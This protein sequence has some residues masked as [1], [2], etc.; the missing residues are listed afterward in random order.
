[1]LL[2]IDGFPLRYQPTTIDV[3]APPFT[4]HPLGGGQ[5]VVVESQGGV[6]VNANYEN[7]Q[8]EMILTELLQRRANVG[9]HTITF[10]DV[11]FR[12]LVS[13]NVYMPRLSSNSTGYDA[14]GCRIAYTAF[15]VAFKEIIPALLPSRLE[16][17]AIGSG[18]TW[19]MKAPAA[20]KVVGLSGFSPS[21]GAATV[22]IH[23]QTS[24][25]N[26]LSVTGTF[27]GDGLLTGFT[28]IPNMTYIKDDELRLVIA[29][30]SGNNAQ[31]TVHGWQ[32]RP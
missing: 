11:Q 26:Y 6:T 12:K 14:D 13:L 28:V 16:F 4:E 15:T 27:G 22:Q 23:N 7:M 21:P 20:G 19:K 30:A 31:V 8:I 29:G 18:T 32:F 24:G 2:S 3:I 1:M 17:I 9:I 10:E 5:L 25:I